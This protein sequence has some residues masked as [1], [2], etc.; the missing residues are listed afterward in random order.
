MQRYVNEQERHGRVIVHHQ[1]DIE[2]PAAVV[3][4][5]R[6]M[7]EDRHLFLD[8]MVLCFGNDCSMARTGTFV[9]A[10]VYI[11]TFVSPEDYIRHSPAIRFRLH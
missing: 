11:M 3:T 7:S 8:L 10:R 2:A 1:Y 5:S 4:N 9:L 6:G